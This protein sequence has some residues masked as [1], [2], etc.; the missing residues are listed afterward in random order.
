[1]LFSLAWRNL[2]RRPTRTWLSLSSMAFTAALL[3]LL[4]SFQLGMYDSLKSSALKL[5]D[6]FAQIQ[7]RGFLDNPDVSK[8]ISSP[9]E[10]L[11]RLK[12]IDHLAI[13]PR[14]TAYAILANNQ[15]SYGA[16]IEGIDPLNEPRVTTLATTVHQG[17]YLQ[18]QDTQAIIMGRTLAQN[19]KLN[20]GDKVT[21]LSSAA[22]NTIAADSLTLVG[23][24]DTGVSEIDRQL[25]QIPLSRF[26]QTFAMANSVNLLAIG[27]QTL[28]EVDRHLAAINSIAQQNNLTFNDWSMLRPDVK[29]AI[30]LDFSTAMLWYGAMVLIVT[31]ILLNTLLMSVF[32]RQRE[33]GILLA[34]GMRPQLTGKMIWIELLLLALLGNGIGIIVG[35]S[36]TLWLQHHGIGLGKFSE[37]FAQWGLPDRVYPQLSIVSAVSGPLVMMCFV[38][39][40]GLVPYH[41]LRQVTPLMA[42]KAT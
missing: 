6:G 27:G 14:A 16:S 29:Q 2:W 7:P 38:G 39:I 28:R 33:F 24:F 42:M 25:A 35:S 5:L 17:R 4:L 40:A 18:P 10:L 22:D 26:Q 3:V 41:Y 36:I 12:H 11:A 32:E 1:M 13:T 19:L 8:T 23:T 30:T 37:L 9:Q 34:I 20:L 31:F 21:L 15:I